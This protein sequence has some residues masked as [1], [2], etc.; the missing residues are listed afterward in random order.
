MQSGK[1]EYQGPKPWDMIQSQKRK[2]IWVG[3]CTLGFFYVALPLP[4]CMAP[5]ADHILRLNHGGIAEG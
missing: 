3:T 4:A 1:N 5:A 2:L